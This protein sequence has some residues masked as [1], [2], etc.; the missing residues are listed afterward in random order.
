M[1]RRSRRRRPDF[2]DDLGNESWGRKV[3]PRDQSRGEKTLEQVSGHSAEPG[4]CRI[5]RA[6]RKNISIVSQSRAKLDE[7]K[8]DISS[9]RLLEGFTR[10]KMIISI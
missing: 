7:T 1:L 5:I 2:P 8:L 3:E 10:S 9:V 6:L 4:F